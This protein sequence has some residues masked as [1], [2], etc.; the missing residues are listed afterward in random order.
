MRRREPQGAALWWVA[1][2]ETAEIT[3]T[4]IQ[5]LAVRLLRWWVV[6]GFGIACVVTGILLTLSP[7]RSLSVLAGVVGLAL[8]LTGLTEIAMAQAAARPWLSYLT[9]M[10]W[11]GAGVVAVSWRGI[12]IHAL[13]IAVGVGL[14]VGGAVKVWSAALG[15]GDE[16]FIFVLSGLTNIIVGII[17][18]SWPAVTV[19]VLGVVFGLRTVI[20]GIGVMAIALKLRSHASDAT[21]VA[22]EKDWHRWPRSLRITGA[23]IAFALAF[24]GVALSVAIHR[25]QPN[26]PGDFY[27]A[28]SPLPDSPPGTV[29]RR[30]VIDDFY[31]ETTTYRVLYLSTG[32]NGK[33]TAVSGLVIVPDSAPA[34]GGRKIIA[35]THG[36]VG[37]AS[38][39]APSLQGKKWAISMEGISQFVAAGYVIAASDYQGL[40]TEGPHPYLVGKSEGMNELDNVRAARALPKVNASRDFAVW[41][42]S[43]GGQASLFT[44]QIAAEYAPELHLVAVAGGAPV[45]DVVELFSLNVK[46]VLGR[47]LISMALEALSQVYDDARLEDIVTPAARPAVRKI[48]QNCLYSRPQIIASVPNSL[49]LSVTFLSKPPWGTEPWKTIAA[50]N[51]PGNAIIDAPVM[52]TQGGADKIVDPNATAQ[53]IKRMCDNGQ[54]VHYVLYDGVG[55]LEGGLHAAPDVAAWIA[56]RFASK[57]APSS[58]Q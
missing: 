2:H 6:F 1:N 28:P 51:T 12:T 36:T 15:R 37:V 55:H 17:A 27:T 14:A 47:I 45:P 42:H 26:E 4:R 18:I 13:A 48:A 52:I 53:L 3:L 30:E 38:R 16:R 44:G 35:Y 56:D 43:Q 29:I 34:T 54:V 39:C 7:S 57:P 58:C 23:V 25:S 5:F 40:G 22:P 11:I 50:T 31:P 41:G 9:G 19:L 32:Y 8:V 46:T 20:F 33:P 24:G 49:A 21:P 10:L